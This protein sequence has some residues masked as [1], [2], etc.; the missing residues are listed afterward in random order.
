MPHV[1]KSVAATVALTIT[2][3]GSFPFVY[4]ANAQVSSETE[5]PGYV[6]L[7]RLADAAP[8][9][10]RVQVKKTTVVDPARAPDVAPGLC[11]RQRNRRRLSL[12]QTQRISVVDVRVSDNGDGRDV[13]S[14]QTR[15][16][17]PVRACGATPPERSP[18]SRRRA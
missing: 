9:V 18:L 4:G 8:Q 7:A 10:L 15:R 3:S 16:T 2:I 11:E 14:R 6:A 17:G 1:L 5:G 13:C 12:T